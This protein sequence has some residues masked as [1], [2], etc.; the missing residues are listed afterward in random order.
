[1][2]RYIKS[3]TGKFVEI[4]YDEVILDDNGLQAILYKIDGEDIWIPRSQIEDENY[5]GNSI[6][7]TEW[8]ADKKGLI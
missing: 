4:E 6:L 1:M 7:I 3:D 5:T 2:S 8:I